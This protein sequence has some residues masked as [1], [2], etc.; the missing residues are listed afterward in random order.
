MQLMIAIAIVAVALTPSEGAENHAVNNALLSQQ[1]ASHLRSPKQHLG[2]FIGLPPVVSWWG[3]PSQRV[4]RESSRA[5]TGSAQGAPPQAFV[6]APGLGVVQCRPG[7]VPARPA[8]CAG[9]GAKGSCRV[10]CTKLLGRAFSLAARRS[11]NDNI[12]EHLRR[13]GMDLLTYSSPLYRLQAQGGLAG[14]PHDT[15]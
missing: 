15:T 4:A 10:V 3:E 14:Q 13:L 7:P 12:S 5:V 6:A 2:E 1:V 8:P 11:S 9:H